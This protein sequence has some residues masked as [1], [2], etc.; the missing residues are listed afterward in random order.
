MYLVGLK[1]I[2]L[3]TA[4][5]SKADRDTSVSLSL[6]VEPPFSE[7]RTLISKPLKSHHTGGLFYW[8]SKLGINQKNDTIFNGVRKIVF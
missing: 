6:V 8:S 2:T 1:R 7:F 4:L 3:F 5:I